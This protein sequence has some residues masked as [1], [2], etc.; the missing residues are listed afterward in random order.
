MSSIAHGV[1]TMVASSK[2]LKIH[3]R[4]ESYTVGID[5]FSQLSN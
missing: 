5:E 3:P 4:V 1:H 2:I